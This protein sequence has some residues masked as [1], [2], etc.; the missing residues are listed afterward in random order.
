MT[1]KLFRHSIF[2]ETCNSTQSFVKEKVNGGDWSN[3]GIVR[4][5]FQTQ[6]MG[7]AGSKWESEKGQN[8][9]FSLFLQHTYL[10]AIDQFK[11]SA[12]LSLSIIDA[13][14]EL[15]PNPSLLQVKWPNDI[16]YSDQK[17]AGI[18]IEHQLNGNLVENSIVGMG[19]NVNQLQFEDSLINPISLIQICN[20]SVV[21]DEVFEKIL[22]H[23]EK[24]YSMINNQ[25]YKQL[26]DD[27]LGK[28]YRKNQWKN[29]K[30]DEKIVEGKILGIDEFGFLRMLIGAE[31]RTFD[32]RDLSY[33]HG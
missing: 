33:I 15:V 27:Y 13:L 28:L 9:L 4:C 16:Y 20:H 12:A 31:I 23:L 24:R 8:L 21:L 26:S 10:Q 5:L 18:L 14:Q 25:E 22:H 17:L 19:I 2:L 11:L 29:Y 32:V 7:Q 30:I 3:N 6:G 1:S